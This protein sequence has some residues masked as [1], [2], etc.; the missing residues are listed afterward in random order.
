[1]T[2]R[3]DDPDPQTPPADD[4]AASVDEAAGAVSDAGSGRREF[5]RQMSGDA[6]RTAG[7][8]AGFSSIIRRSVVAAGGAAIRDLETVEA[9][10]DVPV[11]EPLRDEAPVQPAPDPPAAQPQRH[12]PV[13][14]LTPEQHEF[15]VT[16]TQAIMAV[17]DPSGA[18]HL[19]SSLY[20]W[21][22]AILRLPGRLSTARAI[23]IDRDPR[24]SVLV[25]DRATEAWVAITGTASLS[26]VET[27]GAEMLQILAR[28]FDVAV[29]ARRWDEMRQTGDQVVI[30][31][32]PVRFVWR[33]A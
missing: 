26:S 27:V 25:E 19:T 7:R 21:D 6:V 13:A 29:A 28:Y 14:G 8:V 24:V 2:D 33:P 18:P 23:D 10:G 17:N 12:D 5:L 1:M 22:G 20:H 32:L 11:N 30:H 9:A 15:L 4:S 3:R 31:V 16:G